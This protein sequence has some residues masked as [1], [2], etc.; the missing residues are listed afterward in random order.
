MSTGDL[1]IMEN[2]AECKKSHPSV[3]EAVSVLLQVLLK[4]QFSER[5]F[6]QAELRDV[7]KLLLAEITTTSAKAEV[8]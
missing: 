3:A 6:T 7:A 8:E 4:G 2:I 1:W 5:Q